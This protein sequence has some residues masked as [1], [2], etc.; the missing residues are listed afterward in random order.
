MKV[1]RERYPGREFDEPIHCLVYV[2]YSIDG[3]F[4]RVALAGCVSTPQ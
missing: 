1:L 4:P 2:E 3:S